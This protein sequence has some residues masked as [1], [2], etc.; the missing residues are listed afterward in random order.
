MLRQ[1][2]KQYIGDG[3]YAE[4]DGWDIILTTED[5][6]TVH[7]TIVLEPS[8][9]ESLERYIAAVRESRKRDTE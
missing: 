7:N 8:V 2:S 5:G 6:I 9:V 4:D 3:V 1:V